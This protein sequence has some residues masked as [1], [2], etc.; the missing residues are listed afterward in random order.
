M[1]WVKEY[2]IPYYPLGDTCISD[3]LKNWR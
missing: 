1:K 3:A 2:M